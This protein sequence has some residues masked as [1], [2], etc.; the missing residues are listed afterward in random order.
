MKR[1]EH[2]QWAKDRAGEYLEKRDFTAAYSSFYS[3]M[4]KYEELKDNIA[5]K[6]GITVMLNNPTVKSV[7]NFIEGFN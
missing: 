5:L 4:S 6:L 7:R 1:S 3:D 2:L